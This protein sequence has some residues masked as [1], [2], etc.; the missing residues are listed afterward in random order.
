MIVP[1]SSIH[2]NHADIAAAGRSEKAVAPPEEVAT[3]DESDSD[4]DS[5]SDN[6]SYDAC[7]ELFK[8]GE[9]LRML[10][11]LELE[12]EAMRE[13]ERQTEQQE[14]EEEQE[15]DSDTLFYQDYLR[16]QE[17][18]YDDY[19]HVN[20]QFIDF[21]IIDAGSSSDS[22]SE[23][24]SNSITIRAVAP[25]S[26]PLIIE[27]DRTVGKG[28]FVWDAGF[29]LAESVLNMEQKETQWLGRRRRSHNSSSNSNSNSNQPTTI[30]EL[31]AGTG[32]T[33]LMIAKAHPQ[34]TVHLTDLFQLQPLLS[35][36]CKT[37]PGR[38]THGVLEWGKPIED[39]TTYDIILGA[40]VVAGIYDSSGLAKTIYDL[41]HKNTVVY[42]ACRERLAGVIDRFES[43]MHELFTRV[44]KFQPQSSNLSPNVFIMK[45]SGKRIYG[46]GEDEEGPCGRIN[47]IS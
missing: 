8:Q 46:T 34:T 16:N 35:K 38:A 27:Q 47:V 36:N 3:D 42:L 13:K 32:I 19:K 39:G 28:G 17:G 18:I 1:T 37:C 7:D 21:G 24:D 33:S 6:S 44:E 11:K 14:E 31:G 10:R 5:D 23:C 4:S 45:V 15:D 43:Y 30:I 9:F 41:S 25:S 29:V 12:D 26:S 20:Y 40:D 22:D 2:Q